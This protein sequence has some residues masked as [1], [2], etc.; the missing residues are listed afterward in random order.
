MSAPYI[1][2]IAVTRR[3]RD[4]ETEQV[5]VDAVSLS[6]GRRALVALA[7]PS[8]SG[9]ST[10]LG[11]LGGV[12]TPTEGDVKIAGE[13]IVA[14]R[15]HHRTAHRRAHVG[16]VLQ[17]LALVP[18]MSVLEN[19]LLPLVPRGGARR[20]DVERARALLA[21]LSLSGKERKRAFALSG[22]ERQRAAIARALITR[23]SALLL[24]EPTAHLDA[25]NAERV[26]E[27]LTELAEEGH[28]ILLATHDPRVLTYAGLTR[29]HRIDHGRLVDS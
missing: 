27:V 25:E 10:L 5:A 17:G 26:L 21:R 15:D 20:D 2:A 7:G 9:K 12:L 22:G 28:A 16:I 13:S 18:A 4:G 1:E 24:D 8:G 19:V 3:F 23:P 6:V 14:M 11:L 29:V